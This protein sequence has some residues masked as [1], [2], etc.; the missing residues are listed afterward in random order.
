[1][2]S[3]SLC[4]CVCLQVQFDHFILRFS[5]VHNMHS[6]TNGTLCKEAELVSL[7][8]RWSETVRS[9]H[10]L[11]GCS[12]KMPLLPT[13]EIGI[14]AAPQDPGFFSCFDTTP[15]GFLVRKCT[16]ASRWLVG[17]LDSTRKNKTVLLSRAVYV[18]NFLEQPV[19]LACCPGH[20]A[21]FTTQSS[22]VH[23]QYQLGMTAASK[24][25]ETLILCCVV[26]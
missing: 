26:C 23:I 17:S 3:L 1:M 24:C 18:W 22:R 10:R 5:L 19:K 7:R 13:Q 4:S 8:H 20:L 25:C 21:D 9:C 14:L 2:C 12:S 11:Q 15:P 16:T 6:S